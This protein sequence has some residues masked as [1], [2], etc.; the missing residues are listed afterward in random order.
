[1]KRKKEAKKAKGNGIVYRSCSLSKVLK[2][3]SIQGYVS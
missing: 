3:I 1:M 2:G